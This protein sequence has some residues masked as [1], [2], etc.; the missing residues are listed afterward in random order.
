MLAIRLVGV[1]QDVTSEVY[2]VGMQTYWVK[3]PHSHTLNYTHSDNKIHL[4]IH[5]LL[6]QY[7]YSV[8]QSYIHTGVLVS[9]CIPQWCGNALTN[10]WWLLE[11][12][13]D[14]LLTVS[15]YSTYTWGMVDTCLHAHCV[16]I[17][18]CMYC[19]TVNFHGTKYI[20][21][22]IQLLY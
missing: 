19:I 16:L 4:Y 6:Y 7:M 12:R 1:F 2:S 3:V 21:G 20:H 15:L 11:I 8:H 9:T 10:M 5:V 17:L 13:L 18:I 22:Y 14:C